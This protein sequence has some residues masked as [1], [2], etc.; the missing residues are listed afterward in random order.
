MDITVTNMDIITTGESGVQKNPPLMN[1]MLLLGN[2]IPVR[3][4]GHKR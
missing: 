1:I 2:T 4:S 3:H